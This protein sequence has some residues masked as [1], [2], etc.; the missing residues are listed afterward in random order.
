MILINDLRK[1]A[2]IT[3]EE[4]RE[5]YRGS[6]IKRTKWLGFIRNVVVAMGNSG[7]SKMIPELKY[8]LSSKYPMIHRHTIW[9]LRK[10]GTSEALEAIHQHQEKSDGDKDLVFS[11]EI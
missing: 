10:I 7:D 6:P 5:R 8:L 11:E 3:P 1:L 4:F 2:Q 9:A